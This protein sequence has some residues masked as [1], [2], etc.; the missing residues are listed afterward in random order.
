MHTEKQVLVFLEIERGALHPMAAEALTAGKQVAQN[1][2]AELAA[3]IMG[4][5]I[6]DTAQNV[7]RYG[8]DRV[9]V[10]EHAS[11]ETY[12]GEYFC[13]ALSELCRTA[14]PAVILMINT[15][16]GLDLAPRLA[17]N[18]DAGLVTDCVAI[19]AFDGEITF[20]K[21]IYS[22]N[23]MAVYTPVTTPTLV[24]VRPRSFTALS[25]LDTP[26]GEIV[27]VS[28]ALDQASAKTT[29]VERT[30]EQGDG[31]RLETAERIVAGGRGIGK[32][33]GFTLLKTMAETLGAA[34][35][36][37]RPPCD[38]G[39][40]S[41]KAQVGQTGEIVAPGLYIAVGISG[42]T[43]H[44]AG[45]AGSKTIVAI[46]KDPQANIF[47]IADYGVVGNYEDIIPVLNE[48][49]QEILA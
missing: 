28:V 6:A 45:M 40:V 9:Y 16:I 22:G 35:G 31:I 3:V 30:L 7:R 43:Q 32:A 5:G 15:L 4:S 37:S 19:D 2:R 44:L 48:T 25:F 27:P 26:L 42:S 36:A 38:L 20:T 49:L 18:L 21:P 47:K 23:I 14:P 1:L 34:I 13:L 41:S 29:L 12:H 46:N 33:E 39:W 8:A 11:L 17:W 10:V 24:T